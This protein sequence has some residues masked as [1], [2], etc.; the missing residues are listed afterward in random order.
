VSRNQ[1]DKLRDRDRVFVQI[2]RDGFVDSA[3]IV[4]SFICHTR[5][6]RCDSS[7]ISLVVVVYHIV[8]DNFRS[9]LLVWVPLLANS[10]INSN[11]TKRISEDIRVRDIRDMRRDSQA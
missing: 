3:I 4:R 7:N 8:F 2:R 1:R 5:G 10:E 9:L 6:I 11:I